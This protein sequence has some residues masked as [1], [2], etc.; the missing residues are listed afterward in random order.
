MKQPNIWYAFYKMPVESKLFTIERALNLNK[1]D[2]QEVLKKIENELY[3]QE[4]LLSMTHKKA[5]IDDAL[6]KEIEKIKQI[7]IKK[8]TN[9]TGKKAK[10]LKV[11]FGVLIK[12]MREEGYSYVEIAEYLAKYHKF[13]VDQSTI[14]RFCLKECE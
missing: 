9:R 4:N 8:T 13:K 2:A 6:A 5:N 1:V 12:K 10:I 7:R 11:R 14:Y 3:R